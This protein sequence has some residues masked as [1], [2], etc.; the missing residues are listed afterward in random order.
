MVCCSM[1][2]WIEV[3]SWSFILSNSSMRH[4][5]LSASTKAPPSRVHSEVMRVSTDTSRETDRAGTL[6]GCEDGPMGCLLDVLE[7]LG[8]GRTRITEQED[9][10]ISSDVV[11][12]PD[13]GHPAEQG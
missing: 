6:S 2:S 5:P 1:A 13:L 8:L 9:V 4:V 12:G 7:H 11:R 3:R 10:D